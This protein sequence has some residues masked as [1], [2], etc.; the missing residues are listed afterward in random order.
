MNWYQNGL[1]F[2]CTKCGHCCTGGPGYVWI[3][4][5]D[6]HR[7]AEFLGI[8][9]REFTNKYVRKIGER[10]SLIEARN[11]DCIFYE[12]GCKIYP[13]RPTQCR[14]FPFWKENLEKPGNWQQSAKNCEGMNQGKF[15]SEEEIEGLMN[16]E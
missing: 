5:E 15:Y 16:E 12:S 1:K 8:R 2:E 9:V 6:M 4:V 11:E 7:I 14:T 3:K 10:Y 13:V